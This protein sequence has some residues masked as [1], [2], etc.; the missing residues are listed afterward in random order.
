VFSVFRRAGRRRLSSGSSFVKCRIMPRA[1][2]GICRRCSPIQLFFKTSS[3]NRAKART[4][5]V[6]SAFPEVAEGKK[7]VQEI[8]N[9]TKKENSNRERGHLCSLTVSRQKNTEGP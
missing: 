5:F 2:Y 4:T 9:K 8:K 7:E 3:E 1:R 6:D